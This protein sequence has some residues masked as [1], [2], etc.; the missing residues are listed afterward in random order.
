M[1]EDEGPFSESCQTVPKNLAPRRYF[2]QLSMEW[3]NI[4]KIVRAEFE[5]KWLRNML[6]NDR[7]RLVIEV[8]K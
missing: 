8:L 3:N 2:Q 1:V 5:Q 6:E 4:N 7:Q